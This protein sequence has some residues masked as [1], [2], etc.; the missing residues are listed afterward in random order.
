MGTTLFWWIHVLSL[1]IC[2]G[3]KGH[4]SHRRYI[5]TQ[6]NVRV[7]GSLSLDPTLRLICCLPLDLVPV[8]CRFFETEPQAQRTKQ[9]G[10]YYR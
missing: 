8:L 7:K 9:F 2:A 1:I 10:P 3:F 5:Y 4:D 6:L